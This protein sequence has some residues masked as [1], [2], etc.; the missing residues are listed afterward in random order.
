MTIALR[1]AEEN[2]HAE[3]VRAIQ[4]WWGDSRSPEQARELALLL[5]RL[6]VEHFSGTSLVAEDGGDMAGFLIGFHSADDPVLAYVHFVGIDPRR[7]H[8]GLARRLYET[9]FTAAA[10]AG[11]RRVGAVTSPANHG[12]IAFHRR[13]GFTLK[14]GDTMVD[15]VPVHRDYD[16]PGQDRVVFVR[17]LS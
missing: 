15:G 7:R 1:R 10:A 13:M 17:E 11:R 16:G 2:D 9:F 3:M 6:F 12:S 5:P 4:T 8:D 14:P